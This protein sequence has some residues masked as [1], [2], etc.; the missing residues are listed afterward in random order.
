MTARNP[1]SRPAPY[2][3]GSHPYL[4]AGT[5]W[6]TDASWPFP[7]AAWLPVDDRGIPPGQPD[8]VAGTPYDFRE[9]RLVGTT[10][11]DTRSPV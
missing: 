8:E 11:I 3:T 4:T 1:G 6:S 2:G 5:P 10:R 9:P 7:P